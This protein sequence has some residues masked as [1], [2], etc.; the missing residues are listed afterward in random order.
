M[1]INLQGRH[2]LTLKDFSPLEIE[3]LL[4]LSRDL[5]TKKRIGHKGNLLQNKNIVLIFDKPSTRTRCAFE[6]AAY[7]EGGNVT[8]LSNSHMGK[9]ESIE[10]T[11]IVLGRMYDG[12]EFRGF[13]HSEAETLAKY[14]GVP[15]WNGLTD[16]YHPTQILA[17]FLTTQ[18]HV[19]KP[20][21]KVKLV[22][23]GDARN[24]MGNS[25]MIGAAKMGMHFVGL[26]PKALW[27]DEKLVNEMRTL[28]KQT[29][30]IIEYEEDIGKAVQGADVI[31]TDVWVSMGEED[32][33]ATRIKQLKAYQVNRDML[34]KT[35]NSD[36][37]FL[38]C[39]PAFHDLNTEVGNQ[40]H[41]E[42]G[43]T[44]MEVT[45]EVFRS[46]NSKVFDQAENRLHTI[47]AIMVATIGNL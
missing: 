37:I 43:L 26:A 47:K 29:S 20:L 33:F 24:N 14:A 5:K 6:C 27:A 19:H 4:N 12:I 34:N 21:N 30:A 17:D 35:K 40:V 31:Y 25:L 3:Y 22:Y 16:Q 28:A 32:Q 36:V 46:R 44:E 1:S 38:H 8:F 42:F 18:E 39:L 2:F 9:K 15:V 23:V 41:K 45:D 13:S 7:D 11:A 10:D